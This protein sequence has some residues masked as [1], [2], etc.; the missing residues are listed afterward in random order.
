MPTRAIFRGRIA[1]PF[2]KCGALFRPLLWG[3]RKLSHE[4]FATSR[5]NVRCDGSEAK[6]FYASKYNL[7][8]GGR[9]LQKG[10]NVRGR[11]ANLCGRRA[12]SGYKIDRLVAADV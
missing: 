5:L 2:S 7:L 1:V 11:P 9:V 6:R 3:Y 8:A 10:T 12:A 4:H